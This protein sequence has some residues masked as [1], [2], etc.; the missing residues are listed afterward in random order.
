MVHPGEPVAIPADAYEALESLRAAFNRLLPAEA[1][2]G[3]GLKRIGDDYVAEPSLIVYLPEKLPAD[4]LP[5]ETVIPAHWEGYATDVVESRPEPV[6]LVDD[7]SFVDP[8][9]GGIDIGWEDPFEVHVG[10]LGCVAQLRGD[11]ARRL[12]TADHVTPAPGIEMF[13]PHPLTAQSTLLGTVEAQGTDWDAALLVTDPGRGVP[14][15]S[16]RDVGPLRGS[17]TVTVGTPVR[18]RG[19]TTG[20]TLGFVVAHIPDPPGQ[21]GQARIRIDTF[22][23]GG[24]FLWHGDSGSVA[25]NLSDEV[26]GLVVQADNLQTDASGNPV[27]AVG[28]ALPIQPVLDELSVEIGVSPPAISRISPDTAAGVLAVGGKAEIDG[29]GFDAG[30][31]VTFNGVDALSVVP[32][33]PRRLVVVPPFLGILGTVPVVATNAFGESSAASSFTY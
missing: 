20:L 7:T 14:A 1:A 8:P 5:S 16:V 9:R 23:P 11:G 2:F 3:V 13:Q 30:T 32:A 10:T 18:K 12:L 4:R 33:S 25:V 17:S 29:A 6:A 27:A 28:M 15:C 19:R 24:L 22:P 21:V 31:R 26:V